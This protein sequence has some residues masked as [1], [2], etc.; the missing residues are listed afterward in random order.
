MHHTWPG[1]GQ[2]RG[3]P[4][5]SVGSPDELVVPDAA[6]GRL[7]RVLAPF[8]TPGP[9]LYLYFPARTQEQPKLRA[10]I[11]LARARP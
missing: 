4:L 3:H 5:T 2:A 8:V 1:P 11:E 9:G 7:E 10:L 6:A